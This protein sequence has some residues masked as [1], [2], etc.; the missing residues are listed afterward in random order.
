M[1]DI[2]ISG[3]IITFNEENN[4]ERCLKSLE[5]VVDEIVVVDSYS[6]DRTKEICLKF[7]VR[8]Y[9]NPFEGHI[10]QK[11]IAL[12]FASND[13]VLSLDA[14]EAL[15]EE[16]KESILNFK[17]AQ[18]FQ[19]DGCYF[20]RRTR[21]VDK[22]IF[23]CGWYPDKKLRLFKKSKARWGGKNPHDIIIMEEHSKT[24][25]LDGD[26]LHYSYDSISSHINQ[27]NKFTTIAAQVHYEEGVRS[28][29][30][31]IITRP[32]LKF[33]R[34]YFFK[35]GFMDGYYGLV[36]CLINALSAFLKYTKIYELQHSKRISCDS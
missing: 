35:K 7:G 2:L 21:Y 18:N 22:W 31:K 32:L 10:E 27:T 11:N 3:V 6:R 1:K 24:I 9:E 8:F 20:N 33:F 16:L 23:Y 4:I 19:I 30:F 34:D 13:F 17:R 29:L 26:L 14:D 12:S 15:S 36:I 28:S 25:H 5:G